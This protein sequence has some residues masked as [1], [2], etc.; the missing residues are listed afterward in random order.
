[1]RGFCQEKWRLF[2]QG[3]RWFATENTQSI[4]FWISFQNLDDLLERKREVDIVSL[5]LLEK[6]P[7]YKKLSLLKKSFFF[8][9]FFF[10]DK[11]IA[12]ET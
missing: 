8:F 10:R 6:D 7:H 3:S 1:M 4:F 9:F 2:W 5:I 12:K 11:I